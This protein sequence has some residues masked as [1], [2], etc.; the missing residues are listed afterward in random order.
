MQQKCDLLVSQ[1]A[2]A[3]ADVAALQ[4]ALQEKIGQVGE[5]LDTSARSLGHKH[6]EPWTGAREQRRQ[7]AGTGAGVTSNRGR[8]DL[9][10]GHTGKRDL[11]QGQEEWKPSLAA[12]CFCPAQCPRLG[13]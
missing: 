3:N 1:L 6:E 4:A 2:G 8:R 12:V 5:T 7:N 10:Q 11:G 9:G 13:M